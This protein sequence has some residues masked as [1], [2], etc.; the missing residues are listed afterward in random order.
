MII[1][2]INNF[3]HNGTICKFSKKFDEDNCLVEKDGGTFK[4]DRRTW[5]NVDKTG[6]IIGSRSQIPLN[7]FWSSTIHKVQGLEL[8][9]A[10]MHSGYEF[11]GGL[12]YTALSRVKDVNCVRLQNFKANLCEKKKGVRADK[13][14][15]LC[16]P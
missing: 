7:L 14:N 4:V 3:L 10:V 12:L 6:K 15:Q 11:V 8:Q 1:F 5:Q 16:G 9:S 13:Q 2:N